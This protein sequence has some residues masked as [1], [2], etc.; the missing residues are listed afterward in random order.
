M[1]IH[2]SVA[3][4]RS[5]R[6]ECCHIGSFCDFR[7]IDKYPT[8]DGKRAPD[9][10]DAATWKVAHNYPG[11]IRKSRPIKPIRVFLQ[12]GRHDLDNPLGNWP[13]A[14]EQMA[15]ALAYS[16][17]KYKFVMGEGFHNHKHGRA[18]L[19]ES[20]VWLWSDD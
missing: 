20:L 17:Y 11:L 5:I 16:G 10:Q 8:L 15:K 3:S 14:N 19:P 2:G 4:A 12:D 13:L 9:A 1:R 6:A 18:I 7:G